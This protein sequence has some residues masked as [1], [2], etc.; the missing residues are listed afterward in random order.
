M[1]TP[2]FY[3]HDYETF[4]LNAGRAQ[5]AQFAG[6]RTDEDFNIIAEPL[7]LYCKPSLDTLPDPDSCV[8]TGITPAHAEQKG[9][10]EAEFIRRIHQELST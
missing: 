1:A 5:V 7:V 2:T 4:S 10:T 3:W 9:V 8:I 6:V